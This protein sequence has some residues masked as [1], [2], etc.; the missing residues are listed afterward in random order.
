MMYN[1]IDQQLKNNDCGVSVVKTLCNIF[2]IDISRKYIQQ[3]IFTDEQGSRITDI[4]N[5]LEQN[6]FPCTYKILDINYVQ[7]NMEYLKDLF[8]FILPIE[9]KQGLHYVVINGIKGK[10]LKILD[11]SRNKHY[12]LSIQELKK[13][14][15]FSI[16]NWEL[17]SLQ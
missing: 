12:Y 5:F 8:P 15:H 2:Q 17:A 4:K 13:I 9:N 14:A 11:P 6:H 1:S 16:S 10:K 7:G 3:N